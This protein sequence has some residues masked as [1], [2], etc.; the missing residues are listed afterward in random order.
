MADPK[1]I[2]PPTPNTST[3]RK[4]DDQENTTSLNMKTV[5]DLKK[6]DIHCAPKQPFQ[7]PVTTYQRMPDNLYD[8]AQKAV[9]EL[10]LPERPDANNTIRTAE[11]F[12]SDNPNMNPNRQQFNIPGYK[13]DWALS[14]DNKYIGNGPGQVSAEGWA[15]VAKKLGQSA[16]LASPT[17]PQ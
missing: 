16:P 13:G 8:G 17:G 7:Q 9:R 5:A 6:M 12:G 4:E 2:N 11:I 10:N 3:Q 15:N 1:G 14:V